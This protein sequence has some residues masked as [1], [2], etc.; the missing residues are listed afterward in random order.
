MYCIILYFP[1]VH[2]V[3]EME[4]IFAHNNE[5]ELRFRDQDTKCDQKA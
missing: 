5:S 2:V 1:Y 3:F 4:F